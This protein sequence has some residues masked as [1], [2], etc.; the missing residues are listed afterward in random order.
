MAVNFVLHGIQVIATGLAKGS[1]SAE[2]RSA[3]Q[4]TKQ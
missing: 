1:I 2:L 4:A 3:T